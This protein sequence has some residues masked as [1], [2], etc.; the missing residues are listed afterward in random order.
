MSLDHIVNVTITR[1]TQVPSVR[2]FATPLL[3]GFHSRWPQRS[4]AYTS[5]DEMVDDGFSLTDKLYRD[6]EAL[7]SQPNHPSSFKVGRRQT[8]TTQI[9]D[10]YPVNVTPGV[11]HRVEWNSQVFTYTNGSSETVASICTALHAAMAAIAGATRADN[12]TRVTISSTVAGRVN[13]LRLSKS[14]ELKDVS[15]DPGSG[16]AADLTAIYGEDA[17][18]YPFTLDS[19]SEVEVNAA[20][21]WANSRTVLFAA[22]SSDSDL[23]KSVITTDVGSDLV[24]SSAARTF[25]VWRSILGASTPAAWL[26][27]CITANPGR[28]NWAFKNLV[29]EIVDDLS[30]AEI[31]AIEAKRFSYF[32]KRGGLNV[33]FDGRTPMPNEYVDMIVSTDWIKARMQEAVFGLLANNDIVPY[34]DVGIEAVRTTAL[35]TLQRASSSAY[36]ILDRNTI[37]VTVPRLEETTEGDRGARTLPN[38]QFSGRLQGALNRVVVRGNIFI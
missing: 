25:G 35:A 16:V 2:G 23:T 34:T 26:G 37:Q 5:P 36:P 11:I 6:A 10:I 12:T 28:I 4:K 30:G 7:W 15:T 1:Q 14:L 32:V 24:A 8:G 18:W 17:D 20:A 13:R 33:T 27:R 29:G 31:A 21:A 3:V 9:L 22:M 38:V 19:N